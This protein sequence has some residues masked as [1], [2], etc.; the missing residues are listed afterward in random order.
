V[1]PVGM[2]AMSRS[3]LPTV[4][5]DDLLDRLGTTLDLVGD[6]PTECFDGAARAELSRVEVLVT[7]WACPR[8]TA[9]LLDA[10][11]RLRAVVH[12]AGT[13]KN[14]LDAEVFERG[15]AV[16][17]AA[18][19]NAQPVVDFTLSVITLAGKRAFA[20]SAGVSAPFGR[21]PGNA[22]RVV[23]VVGASRIG[24]GVIAG[25]RTAGYH[26]LVAD[27]YLSVREAAALGAVLSDLDSLCGRC[28][29]L[30][31]HA[32]E[33]PET[34]HLLD[35]RRLALLPDGAVVVNTARGSLVDTEALT[36]ACATGRIDACLDVT[37]PEPLPD[38]H[39]LRTM[40]N[41]WLTPHL[42]GAQG[43][44][45]RRLGE[46]AVL[47]VER[48]VAGQPLLGAVDPARFAQLA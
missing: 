1:R 47:E 13:V 24:R 4:L 19:A 18:D 33:L 31:L 25:L 17:S 3:V 9:D 32:P 30:T 40:P 26:V 20:Y 44:E 22:G 14:H 11:P 10:A 35:E 6:R 2:L 7:G 37:D 28:D 27:P 36:R 39:P 16:S 41:V 15:I 42:A 48:F 34:R 43:T 5:P 46:Y 29:I 23:G 8:L 38:G 21:R 12:A 45:I